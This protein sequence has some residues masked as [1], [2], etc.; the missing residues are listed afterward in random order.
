MVAMAHA[1]R[2]PRAVSH[3][4]LVVTA[5]HSGFITR[6]KEIVALRGSPEQI[7]ACDDLF[8][9]R[10]DS[11]EKLRRYSEV[12]GSLYSLKYDSELSKV[13]LSR[14]IW[15]A[16]PLNQALAPYG[17]LRDFDLRP[18]LRL[19]AAPTL[20]LAARHD[21]ICPPEFS[22]EIHELISGSD[23]R[24]FEQSS[25]SIGSDEHQKFLDVVAG[26]LVYQSRAR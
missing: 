11:A 9:G 2:Y 6:A 25:H 5:S 17:C 23:L 21:W 19:I 26:F 8:A 1:A 7:S 12:M 16:E 22:E 14:A 3:L 10:L 24:I 13:A 20:I 15:T 4:I 18:Q